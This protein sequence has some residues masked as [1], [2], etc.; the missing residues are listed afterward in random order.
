MANVTDVCLRVLDMWFYYCYITNDF[1]ALSESWHAI[2]RL[3]KQGGSAAGP[4]TPEGLA[5]VSSVSR[6]FKDLSLP[7]GISPLKAGIGTTW[8]IRCINVSCKVCVRL[9][10]GQSDW[11]RASEGVIKSG[12]R[13]VTVYIS[14]NGLC[15]MPSEVF[16]A[17]QPC[18]PLWEQ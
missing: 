1:G 7:L 8:Q 2:L 10:S 5:L 17:L 9:S 15:H 13:T 14:L 12:S 11:D 3:E 6:A 4:F 18:C 16:T